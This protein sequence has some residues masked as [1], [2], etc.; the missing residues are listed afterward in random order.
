MKENKEQ[1]QPSISHSKVGYGDN[2]YTDLFSTPKSRTTISVEEK[3][4]E[5]RLAHKR[6]IKRKRG[7]KD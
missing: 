5:Q 3:I 7:N 2:M 4:K 6:H 1:K